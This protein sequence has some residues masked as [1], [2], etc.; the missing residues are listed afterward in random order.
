MGVIRRQT[1]KNAISGY[2]GIFLG[3]VNLI[4]IQSHFLTPEELGLT[5]ILY[6]F[7][8]LVGTIAPLGAVNITVK[9][10]PQFRNPEKKHHGYFGFINLF[11]LVGI[12]VCFGLILLLKNFIFNQ[13]RTESP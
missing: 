4:F 7:S 11:P 6:S 12:V 13:Y 1:I 5:R 8:L 3:F 10:F 2:I 9:F